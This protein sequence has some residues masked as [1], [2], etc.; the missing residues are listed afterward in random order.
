[1]SAVQGFVGDSEL[2]PLGKTQAERL[3]D[4]LAATGEINAD[5]FI[6]STL[7][8]ARQTAEIIAPALGL[9]IVFDDGVQE[10]RVGEA[11]GMHMDEFRAKY[12][13]FDFER[14]PFRPVAPGGESWAQF[15]VRVG[16]ALERII[17]QHEGK[18]IVIVCHGGVIDGSFLYF[19]RLST[20]MMPAVALHT[21]NTSITHWHKV[22]FED[23]P[24]EWCLIKYNDDLHRRDI[25]SSVRVPWKD[26]SVKPATDANQPTVPLETEE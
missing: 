15:M 14:N 2:S 1:M 24:P 21:H 11:Q 22:S 18:T 23:R 4:R 13:D 7:L 6:S 3:R 10:R 8:R 5:V 25:G 26:I 9:P 17:R 20:L 16:A 19:F 12:K